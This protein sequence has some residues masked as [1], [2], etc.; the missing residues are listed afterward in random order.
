MKN[1]TFAALAVAFTATGSGAGVIER[2]CLSSGREAANR[3]LCGCIQE[4]ADLTLN[5]GDQRMAADFFRDPH[6]AQEVRQSAN[7]RNEA[8]WQRYKRFGSTAEEFCA[9]ARG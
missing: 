5:G 1:L 3:A 7:N 2:A 4:A 8:F 6:R 9:Y